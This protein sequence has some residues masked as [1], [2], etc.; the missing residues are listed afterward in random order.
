M[1]PLKVIEVDQSFKARAKAEVGPTVQYAIAN[2]LV[3]PTTKHFKAVCT[4]SSN[5]NEGNSK[6]DHSKQRYKK[7]KGKRFHEVSEDSEGVMDDLTEQLQ[8]LFY[9]DVQF[10]AIN[11]GM[12]TAVKCETADGKCSENTFKIDTGADGNL[13]PISMFSKLFSQVSLEALKRTIHRN[14]TLYAYNNTQIKQY[15]TC[16][17]KLSFK[18]RTTIGKFLWSSMRQQS[19]A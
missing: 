14:I 10:N 11:T 17:M 19:L 8:S 5:N 12:H 2:I 7:G 4:S 13:M 1:M 16:N 6:G 9:N 15:R 18:G 3:R